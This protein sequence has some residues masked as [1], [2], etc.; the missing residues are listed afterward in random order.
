MSHAT[1]TP[2]ARICLIT[3]ANRGIGK[4]VALGLAQTGAQVIMVC[5][6]A[7]R[8]RAAQ[9]EI[10]AESGNPQVDLLVADLSSQASIRQLAETVQSQYSHL[11][12]LINNAGVEQYERKLTVDGLETT[13]AINHLAYFLLTNLLL[14]QLTSST[15]ARIINVAS[16]VHKWGTIDFDDLQAERHF[17]TD[18]AYY[19][20]K[21]ANVLFTYELARRLGGAGVTVNAFNPGMTATDFAA[22][23]GGFGGFMAKAWRPFMNSA[24]QS[25]AN[26]VYLATAPEIAGVSGQYFTN[27]K[28]LQSSKTSYDEA[29]AHRL[30]GVSAELVNLPPDTGS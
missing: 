29:L 25:A 5:R 10:Q 3:G 14:D 13:F 30:W 12:V 18:K 6:N 1:G 21:L 28:A 22:N 27:R 23:R 24:E 2:P 9:A 7:E 11:H 19:Q 4:E 15:P 17:T 16:L 26:I 8:G 20:S